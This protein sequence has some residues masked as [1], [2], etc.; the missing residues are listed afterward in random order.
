MRGGFPQTATLQ[1]IVQ[2]QRLLR[3]DI[4]DKVLKCDMTALFGVRRVL[5]LEHTFLYLCL[6]D[7]GLLDMTDLC[8]NLQVKRPTAQHFIE[9]LESTN[10]I[11]R[12]PPYG[13]GK[14]VLRGRFKVYLADAAIAPAVMLKGKAILEDP[15]A[16]CVATETAVFKYL[17]THYYTQ[18]VRFSYWRG[19]RDHEVGLVAEAGGEVVPFEVKY[20]QQHTG[21]RDLKGLTE[22]FKNPR[23]ARGYIVTKSADDFGLVNDFPRETGGDDGWRPLILR[24]PAPLLCYWMGAAESQNDSNGRVRISTRRCPLSKVVAIPRYCHKGRTAC[25]PR[26]RPLAPFLLGIG[27][28][29]SGHLSATIR[30]TEGRVIRFRDIHY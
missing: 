10:L 27:H 17:F 19:K 20:R 7:D 14:E 30:A 15:S 25:A 12:L 6:H 24:V 16:L 13:Y 28:V 3:E 1:S 22:F 2:I 29:F 23:V 21:L 8:A 4:I 18:N 11:Y 5:D 9:L 26:A